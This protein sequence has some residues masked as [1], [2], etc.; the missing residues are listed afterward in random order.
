[1]KLA[2]SDISLEAAELL[3]TLWDTEHCASGHGDPLNGSCEHQVVGFTGCKN[4]P[5]YIPSCSEQIAFFRKVLLKGDS[6]ICGGCGRNI[7]SGWH[8]VIR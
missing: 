4:C 1:M 8:V 3:E 6:D 2:E 5:S 7:S